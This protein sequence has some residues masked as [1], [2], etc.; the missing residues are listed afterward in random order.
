MNLK[1][2][3]FESISFCFKGGVLDIEKLNLKELLLVVH[4]RLLF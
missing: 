1:I 3:L 2:T 4:Q